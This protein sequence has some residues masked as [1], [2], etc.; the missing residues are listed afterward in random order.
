MMWSVI[1]EVEEDRYPWENESKKIWLQTVIPDHFPP[2]GMIRA[3]LAK[4]NRPV[5][6][7]NKQERVTIT[8]EIENNERFQ[9]KIGMFLFFGD[10]S[11][12]GDNSWS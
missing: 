5:Y 8:L 11:I 2:A 3:M 12:K 10:E 9:L 6:E 1:Q 7:R 4:R